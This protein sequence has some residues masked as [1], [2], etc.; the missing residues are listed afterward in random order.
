[1]L[2]NIGFHAKKMIDHIGQVN[3]NRASSLSASVDISSN[4]KISSKKS[5]ASATTTTSAAATADISALRLRRRAEIV[6]TLASA[7][8]SS[9]RLYKVLPFKTGYSFHKKNHLQLSLSLDRNQDESKSSNKEPRDRYSIE[10]L[11]NIGANLDF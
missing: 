3:N 7:G 9:L 2:I 8:D 1:M 5:A 4:Q 10:Y 11:W 6:K